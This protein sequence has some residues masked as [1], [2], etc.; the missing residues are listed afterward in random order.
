MYKNTY[1]IVFSIIFLKN[2]QMTR[3]ILPTTFAKHYN[4]TAA[5]PFLDGTSS[6]Y[7]EEMYN[8][9]LRDPASVHTV[10][11][12]YFDLNFMNFYLKKLKKLF[13]FSQSWDAY[14]R[15]NAYCPPPS[16]A[17]SQPHHVPISQLTHL[18]G[19]GGQ[20]MARGAQLDEKTIDDHLAVQAIIR[21]YQVIFGNILILS[22]KQIFFKQQFIEIHV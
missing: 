9:W 10:N 14:F 4:S 17:P 13:I 12:F 22:I 16:L 2:F 19:G 15:N 20:S 8:S 6:N 1:H 18:L 5:E 11:Y 3:E 7:V 21:S